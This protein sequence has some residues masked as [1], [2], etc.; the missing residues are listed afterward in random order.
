MGE[1]DELSELDELDKLDE[2]SQ[3]NELDELDELDELSELGDQAD[4]A[5]HIY[6]RAPI[7]QSLKLSPTDRPEQVLE[8]LAH[9]KTLSICQIGAVHIIRQP[10]EGGEG[11]KPKDDDC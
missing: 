7:A 10:L 9:L 4:Q 1:L 5:D 8:M 2:L 11:G 6:Q 3:L